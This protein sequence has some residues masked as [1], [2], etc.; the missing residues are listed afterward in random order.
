MSLAE[1]AVNPSWSSWLPSEQGGKVA[2]GSINV[3]TT[4]VRLIIQSL[5]EKVV[6]MLS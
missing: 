3:L 2:T 4:K 5:P 6:N 1:F